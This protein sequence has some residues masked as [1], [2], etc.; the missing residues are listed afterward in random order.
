MDI[1]A[2]FQRIALATGP[3]ADM[4]GLVALHAGQRKHIPFENL[5]VALKRS[6]SLDPDEVFAKLV[7]AKRGGYC[8]EQ[9][10][11]LARVL[12]DVGFEVRPVLAR[13]WL[14]MPLLVPP[15]THA[16]N[17]V[18][19]KGE[20]WIADAGFGAV[21]VSPLPVRDGAQAMGQDGH[22]HR[23]RVDTQFGWMFE[24]AKAAGLEISNLTEFQPQYS[25]TLDTVLSSDLAMSNHWSSTW[26]QSRFVLHRVAS[27]IT[28]T[29]IISLMDQQLT[30]VSGQHSA[31]VDITTTEDL[32]EILHTDFAMTFSLSECAKLL[33]H[34]K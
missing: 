23:L 18:K 6:I 31:A 22:I 16:L 29:G 34:N 13:V 32:Q 33:G 25:F 7:T 1:S 30:R 10:Q 17:L 15:R 24:R 21:F 3:T 28:D 9:N 4:A 5:D 2:Y 20:D 8:Y 11:L 26:P 27:I 19:L 14:A 12:T